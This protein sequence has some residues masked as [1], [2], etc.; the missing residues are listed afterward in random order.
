MKKHITV[1]QIDYALGLCRELGLNCMGNFIFGDQ[2]ETVETAMNT[3]NWWK[4]HPQYRIALQ[5]ITLNTEMSTWPWPRESF[6]IRWSL[7]SGAVPS[8]TP[9]K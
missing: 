9:P 7:L 4:A 5:M 1:E 6:R 3:I 8:P 2:N